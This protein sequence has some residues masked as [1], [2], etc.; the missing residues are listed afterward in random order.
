MFSSRVLFKKMKDAFV[1]KP[2]DKIIDGGQAYQIF[3]VNKS[4]NC[5]GSEER[6]IFYE[7]YFKS[8]IVN[9]ATCSIPIRSID[10]TYIRK[11]ISK[12]NLKKILD[13]LSKGSN[14]EDQPNTLVLR[15]ALRFN[16]AQKTAAVLKA[17][18]IDKEDQSTNF[19]RQK[20]DVFK[21]AM[22]QLVEEV[23]VVANISLVEAREK[24]ERALEEGKH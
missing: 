21:Q 18:W 11:P 17:L 4:K 3:E 16:N 9:A 8:P 13:G 20:Q 10:K 14:S 15:D 24:I 19:S 12:K 1:F 5:D 2:G 6:F 22:E 7:P 23:A